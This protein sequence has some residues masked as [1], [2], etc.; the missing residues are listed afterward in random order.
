MR[1]KE[2]VAIVTGGGKGIGSAYCRGL[3]REG[4]KVVVADIDFIAAKKLCA[5]LDA[6]GSENLPFPLDVTSEKSTLEMRDS[7]LKKFG[8]I[9][10]L[11]NNAGIFPLRKFTEMTYEDWRKVTAVNL[12]G[13]FLC[14]KAVVPKMIEQGKGKI[15]NIAT[16]CV[17]MGYGELVHYTAAK[18][19]VVGFTRALAEALGPHRIN[20][21]T[22]TP[23]LTG[24]EALLEQQPYNF[25][26][27]IA[28]QCIKRRQ[29]PE[30]LVGTIIF[31]ASNDSDMI[32][33]QI[34]NVDGG[35][36]KH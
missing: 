2:K 17:F 29:E 11:V 9:D 19:G 25:A 34:I 12:D 24:T 27:H 16:E 13:V 8:G 28:R 21:N 35:F 10:I 14:T 22:V 32:T 5:E 30:D 31:L 4:A 3:A 26:P 20:V 7:V 33:G 36:N 23:G 1:L 6:K 18:T 15:I